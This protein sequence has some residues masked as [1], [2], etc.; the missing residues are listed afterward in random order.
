M[1]NLKRGDDKWTQHNL[2][3]VPKNLRNSPTPLVD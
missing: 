3:K 1:F 2:Y